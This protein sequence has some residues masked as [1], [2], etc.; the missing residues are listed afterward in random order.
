M[1][2]VVVVVVVSINV[3]NILCALA[4]NG[5]IAMLHNDLCIIIYWRFYPVLEYALAVD[6]I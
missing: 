4:L 1:R 5:A 2:I 3:K 6:R